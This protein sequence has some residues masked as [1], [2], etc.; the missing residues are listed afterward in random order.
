MVIKILHGYIIR[1]AAHGWRTETGDGEFLGIY[2][3]LSEAVNAAAEHYARKVIATE[4]KD[5][6]L[7]Q[8]ADIVTGVKSQFYSAMRGGSPEDYL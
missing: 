6:S 2:D 7:F 3:F 5:A 1:V 4:H 8:A